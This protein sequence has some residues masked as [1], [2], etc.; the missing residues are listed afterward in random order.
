MAL[1]NLMS[2][3]FLENDRSWEKGDEGVLRL[4]EE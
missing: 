1:G 3:T 4:E 2:V